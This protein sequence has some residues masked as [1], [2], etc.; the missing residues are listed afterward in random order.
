MALSDC[1]GVIVCF[2][3]LGILGGM[4]IERWFSPNRKLDKD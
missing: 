4:V 3:A 1:I 2:F